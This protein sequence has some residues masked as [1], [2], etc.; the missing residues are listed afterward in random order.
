MLDTC[1]TVS[2]V[3]A[4]DGLNALA[5]DGLGNDDI[6]LALPGSPYRKPQPC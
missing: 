1:L 2:S 3:G 4:L 5:D 6:G